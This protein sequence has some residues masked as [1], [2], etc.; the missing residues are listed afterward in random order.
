MISIQHGNR[1]RV[2]DIPILLPKNKHS[3]NQMPM[4]AILLKGKDSSQFEN[5]GPNSTIVEKV[6]KVIYKELYKYDFRWLMFS[7][8]DDSKM[9]QF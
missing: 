2:K 5:V 8:E 3:H 6:A 1:K 4:E 7:F 9:I